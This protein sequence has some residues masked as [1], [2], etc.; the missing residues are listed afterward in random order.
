MKR[1]RPDWKNC[2]TCGRRMNPGDAYTTDFDGKPMERELCRDCYE[3]YIRH[4]TRGGNNHFGD[5]LEDADRR[6]G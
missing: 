5:Y 2:T 1:K 3:N 6:Y 4:A